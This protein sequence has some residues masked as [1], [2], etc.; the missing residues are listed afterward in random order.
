M[1]LETWLSLYKKIGE[2]RED[3]VDRYIEE[4]GI[5]DPAEKESIK[6]QLTTPDPITPAPVDYFD[7]EDW[8]RRLDE[9][10]V[11]DYRITSRPSE[12]MPPSPTEEYV[13]DPSA[14]QQL[15]ASWDTAHA[16]LISAYGAQVGGALEDLDYPDLAAQVRD[17]AEAGRAEQQRQADLIA[18]PKSSEEILKEDPES[19]YKYLP[20]HVPSGHEF[21][22]TSIPSLTPYAMGLGLTVASTPLL[23]AAGLTGTGLA[24]A[25]GLTGMSLTNLASSFYVSGQEYER[26]RDDPSVREGLGIDPSARFEDLPSSDKRLLTE[27]RHDMA[28]TTF[29]RRLYTAGLVEM[30]SFAR[31][32][33]KLFRWGA[34]M[35]LGAT[36]E[37]WD[38]AL[39]AENAANTMVEY[40]IPLDVAERMRKKII[41]L[42]PS[43]KK[44]WTQSLFYEGVYGGGFIGVEALAGDKRI[45]GWATSSKKQQE[46]QEEFQRNRDKIKL[47]SEEQALLGT[48]TKRRQQ[49]ARDAVALESGYK[50]WEDMEAQE[51]DIQNS[52]KFKAGIDA[53]IARQASEKKVRE[54]E[55]KAEARSKKEQEDYGRDEVA[56]MIRAEEQSIRAARGTDFAA[57]SKALDREGEILDN[58]LA[59]LPSSTSPV[60]K[61]G[62]LLTSEEIFDIN[63]IRRKREI[64]LLNYQKRRADFEKAQKEFKKEHP[65]K[66]A[67]QLKRQ[68]KK[69]AKKEVDRPKVQVL[70]STI[71]A[72]TTGEV[73]TERGVLKRLFDMY[74]SKTKV[75]YV[76]LDK[77][78][79]TRLANIFGGPEYLADA[80]GHLKGSEGFVHEGIVYL[81]ADN[82]KG[83][84]PSEAINRA[85]TALVTGLFANI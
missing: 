59:K 81:V 9:K 53:R 75:K 25:S 69:E 41:S 12:F 7:E 78:D 21:I 46:I 17:Q 24:I 47:K 71:E 14:L 31:Y 13:A 79:E 55:A 77:T 54:L 35:L 22:R 29:G 49:A 82:I 44:L 38:E 33:S 10:Y 73:T 60:R 51:K 45:D 3:A 23:A 20:E 26:I 37:V 8:L 19:F 83:A 28:Q 16:G 1:N 84:T 63:A 67:E 61:D 70:K 76:I 72:T 39:Y 74:Q 18:Y 30:L 64:Q 11:D 52:Y 65:L 4:Q 68:T 6:G 15:G 32:G 66:T 5:T 80:Q 36:S 42:G 62:T 85:G 58:I 2:S 34:D 56:Q 40:G 43:Q 48:D 57:T 50:N 27:L